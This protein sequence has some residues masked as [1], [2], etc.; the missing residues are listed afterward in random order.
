M[1]LSRHQR[2]LE[3]QKIS[4]LFSQTPLFLLLGN[5]RVDIWNLSI[6]QL[7]SI[8]L[9]KSHEI[10][11]HQG[12][13]GHWRLNLLRRRIRGILLRCR[14]GMLRWHAALLLVVVGINQGE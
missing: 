5:H 4:G 10:H 2:A 14:C 9:R 3:W 6:Q 8:N 12:H 7:R 1:L 13:S 11:L